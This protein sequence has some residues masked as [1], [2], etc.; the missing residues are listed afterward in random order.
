[1]VDPAP[2]VECRMKP[3]LIAPLFCSDCGKERI[4]WGQFLLECGCKIPILYESHPLGGRCDACE[5]SGLL[6]TGCGGSE[7]ACNAVGPCTEEL[8][9]CYHCNARGFL[10]P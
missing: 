8:E 7:V 1:M 6:C 3:D 5:G 10:V 4:G 9:D 2:F